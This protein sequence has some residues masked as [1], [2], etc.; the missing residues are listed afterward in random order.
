MQFELIGTHTESLY[1]LAPSRKRVGVTEIGVMRIADGKWRKAGTSETNWG[2]CC[3]SI[4]FR[5]FAG[6]RPSQS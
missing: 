6:Y 2:C 4:F 1:G 3:S 5:C